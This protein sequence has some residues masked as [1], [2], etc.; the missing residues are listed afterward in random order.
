MRAGFVKDNRVEDL[1]RA[2][3]ETGLWMRSFVEIGVS[4]GRRLSE[5]VGLRA[6]QVISP[7]T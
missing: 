3:A 5:I 2:A 6:E 7:L 4:Y 1:G